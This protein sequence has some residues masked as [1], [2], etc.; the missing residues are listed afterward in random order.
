MPVQTPHA[1]YA[2]RKPDW[3]KLRAFAEGA[4]A[5][6][7]A[8]ETYLPRL[9]GQTDP[10]Y[11][12]YKMRAE[13]YGAIDRTI[14]GLEGAIFLKAPKVEVPKS[15]DIEALLAD[16]DL[17]GQT[18]VEWIR[19]QVREVLTVARG[20]VLIDHT[21]AAGKEQRPY[22]VTYVAERILNWETSILNG[23]ETLTLVVLEEFVRRPAKTDPFVKESVRQFRV[24]LLDVENPESPVYHVQLWTA[25]DDKG[26]TFAM[27]SDVTPLRRGEPL[28]EIPFYFLGATG[29]SITPEKPPLTDVVELCHQHYMAAADYGHGLH[30]VGLPT[31]WVTGV[32]DKD[33]LKIGPSTAIML[34]NEE[35]KVGMLEFTGTG[36]SSLEKRLQ[37]LERKMAILGAR[38]LEEQK[39]EAEAAETVKIRQGGDISTLGAIS[40]AVSRAVEAVV[41]RLLWWAGR[42]EAD[43]TIELNMDFQLVKLSPEELTALVQTWQ[44]GGLSKE[45]FLWNLKRGQ[46][47]PEDRTVEDELAKLETET[48]PLMEQA[49]AAAKSGGKGGK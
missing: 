48:P 49:A 3:T 1:D 6:R 29:Q 5:V 22:L 15:N 39:R 23:V 21:P 47:M 18:L 34:E 33:Q 46:L 7:G 31:P 44:A 38:I 16:V 14:D 19:N 30:W 28:H 13:V 26:E 24:L 11:V 25:A 20:G 36:L 43:V 40:D 10:E 42:D 32:R 37:D 27:T 4:R 9:A 35:A 8:G 45:T 2:Y 41:E 17:M 12:A